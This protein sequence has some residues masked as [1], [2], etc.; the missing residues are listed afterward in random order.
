MAT[1]GTDYGV[2]A[3]DEVTNTTAEGDCEEDETADR[4]SKVSL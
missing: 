3:E 4:R 2:P 1:Y